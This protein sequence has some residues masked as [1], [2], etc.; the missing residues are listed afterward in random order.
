M[1]KTASDLSEVRSEERA[2]AEQVISRLDIWAT[3]MDTRFRIPFTPIRFGIDPIVGLI[4]GA[5]DARG[6]AVCLHF[7]SRIE[8]RHAQ[9]QDWPHGGQYRGRICYRNGADFG[10]AV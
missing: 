1:S 4:P 10:Y 5:G 2:H 3:A 7:R 8:K 6:V 9:T